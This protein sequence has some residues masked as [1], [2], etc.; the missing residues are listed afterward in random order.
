MLLHKFDTLMYAH[1][2]Q[3]DYVDATSC[4]SNNYLG[5]DT[6]MTAKAKD[7]EEQY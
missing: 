2:Q 6:G 7:Q 4:K 3:R 5:L 1:V